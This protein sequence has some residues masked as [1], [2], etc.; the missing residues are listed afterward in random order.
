M[1]FTIKSKLLK[2]FGCSHNL[3]A[4]PLLEGRATCKVSETK[5]LVAN[6]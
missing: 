4:F 1:I 3:Y 5:P 2:H 6:G